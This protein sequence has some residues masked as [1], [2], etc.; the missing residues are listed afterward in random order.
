MQTPI[1]QKLVYSDETKMIS[2]LESNPQ[3][4]KEELELTDSYKQQFS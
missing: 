1:E 3:Y 2:F 4:F